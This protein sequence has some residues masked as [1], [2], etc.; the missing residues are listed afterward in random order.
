MDVQ[1]ILSKCD[2]TLLRQDAASDDIMSACDQGIKYKVATVCIAPC[3]VSG[4]VKYCG[5]AL[6]VSTVI[7]FPNGYNAGSVKIF[8]AENAI[9]S[10]ASELD[11]VI[12]IPMLKDRYFGKIRDEINAIKDVCENRVLKVIIETCLLSDDEKK[13]MCEIVSG[14]RADYIK[15]STG[16]AACGATREDISLLRK[17]CDSRIKIK[18]AGGISTLRDAED[19]LSLGAD[20]LGTSRIIPLVIEQESENESN[21]KEEPENDRYAPKLNVTKIGGIEGEY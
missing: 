10:G 14:S 11:M 21:I 2:H 13:T 17:Y 15:T 8:E 3:H 20:R 16:F 19:F 12:N 9:K 1:Y 5:G 18:A 7:G 6:K 4:A